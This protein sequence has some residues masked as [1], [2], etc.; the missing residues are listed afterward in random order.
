MWVYVS[1]DPAPSVSLVSLAEAKAH[2]RVD[3]DDEDS[4]ITALIAAASEWCEAFTRQVF[5]DREFEWRL[6]ALET[7]Q[8]F[9]RSP[10]LTLV[11]V[12]YLDEA[13]VE[14]TLDSSFYHFVQDNYS[15]SL[16]LAAEQSWPA[17]AVRDDAWRIRFI[18]GFGSAIP[19]SVKQACLLV[20][21]ELFKNRELSVSGTIIQEVPFAAK[22]LLTPY[23]VLELR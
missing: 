15:G 8:R 16:Q 19:T 2:L 5:I 3:Y 23:Q 11:S 20:I 18:A 21:G 1:S 14:Q 4:L 10:A 22:A 12:K 17:T 13:E 9:P 6:G 7:S